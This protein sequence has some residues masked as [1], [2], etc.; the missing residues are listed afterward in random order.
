M[1]T[2]KFLGSAFI[3]SFILLLCACSSVKDASVKSEDSN[4]FFDPSKTVI[5]RTDTKPVEQS[6]SS[7]QVQPVVSKADTGVVQKVVGESARLKTILGEMKSSDEHLW[8]RADALDDLE[9]N[10]EEITQ[11]KTLASNLELIELLKDQNARL[12]DVLDQLKT[13]V[14]QQNLALQATPQK[15]SRVVFVP[16]RSEQGAAIDV[17]LAYNRAL[18][19][20]EEHRYDR[21]LFQFWQLLKNKQAGNLANNC[22]F[23]I[24]VSFF[25][26]QR[27]NDAVP[28]FKKLAD[29]RM[30]EKRESAYLMLG[31]CYEQLGQKQLA[32]ATYETLIRSNPMCEMAN[33]AKLKMSML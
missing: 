8:Q 13:I 4:E 30:F 14:A 3:F 11:R 18:R 17:H 22:R 23:W 26:L 21:A 19:M 1:I 20:Y 12:I 10:A 27:Y 32:K 2:P 16:D 5:A 7:Q 33:V 15:R 29:V 6:T 31:Q 24:G 9:R 28:V 25:N